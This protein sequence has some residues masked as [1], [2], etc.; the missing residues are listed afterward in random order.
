VEYCQERRLAAKKRKMTDFSE[1]EKKLVYGEMW[2]K[3]GLGYIAPPIVQ[4][5]Y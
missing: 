5:L 4:F 3:P 1:E 2:K